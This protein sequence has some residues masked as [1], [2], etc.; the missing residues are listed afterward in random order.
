MSDLHA[1]SL[2]DQVTQTLL[3]R[4]SQREWQIGARMPGQ[5][6][7]SVELG[8]SVVVVREA[9][10]RLKADG[11]VE[12]RQGAGVFVLST[13]EAPRGFK[14]APLVEGD[15]V[16]LAAVLEVRSSI[17]VAAAELAC[18]RRT[19]ED[20][21][22]C[23]EAFKQ[24]RAAL[25]AGG[26]AIVEDFNFHLA[27]AKASHNEFYP[28]LLRYLHHVLIL[29]IRTSRARTR[30]MPRRL[31]QVQD[32][33][34]AILQAIVDGQAAAAGRVMQVH[35]ANAARRLDLQA[36]GNDVLSLAQK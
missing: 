23:T 29:A 32:E 25:A 16:R 28:E 31:E 8:V 4:L 1:L 19:P 14:V 9:L 12:S 11:L 34:A 18:L 24:L 21:H 30:T 13:P 5:N 27:V 15:P 3:T 6:V 10:A 7:L 2:V 33:H 35:L 36:P 26:E 20:I 22:E 17:E